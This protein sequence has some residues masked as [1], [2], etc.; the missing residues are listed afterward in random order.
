MGDVETLAR[1]DLLAAWRQLDPSDAPATRDGL[2][3]LLPGIVD[4]YHLTAAAVTADWYD[5]M[6]ADAGVRRRFAAVIADELSIEQIAALARWSVGPLFSAEPDSDVSLSKLVGGAQRLILNGARATVVGS[7]RRDPANVGWRR[8][9][10]GG[11]DWCQM[12]IGRGA[13]YRA[14]T[15]IFESHDRCR[16]TAVPEFD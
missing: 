11:C 14:E 8:V 4:T 6:R 3:D 10:A 7:V 5:L 12:L 1:R 13:V 9:G 2:L 15:A 16:C